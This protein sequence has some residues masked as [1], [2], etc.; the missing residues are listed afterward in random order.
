MCY[1]VYVVNYTF[2]LSFDMTVVIYI[3]DTQISAS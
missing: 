1:A 2:K 3:K